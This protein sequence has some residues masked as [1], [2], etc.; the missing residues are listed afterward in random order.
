VAGRVT[1]I[2]D[3]TRV[4]T[5]I[6]VGAM[7]DNE[8]QVS[9]LVEIRISNRL[10]RAR[11]LTQ[12]Q[13]DVLS[14]DDAASAMFDA[15]VVALVSSTDVGAAVT[16]IGLGGGLSDWLGARAGQPV[17]IQKTVYR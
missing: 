10:M 17:T 14:A 11:V 2:I 4:A 16:I 9:D 1:W 6:T 12:Q 13:F 7:A 8:M 3:D 5:D 15:D